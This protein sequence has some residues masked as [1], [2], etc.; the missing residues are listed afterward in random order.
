M[1]AAGHW[2]IQGF[3]NCGSGPQS[4]CGKFEELYMKKTKLFMAVKV[5]LCIKHCMY[6]AIIFN[7]EYKKC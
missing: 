3:S 2:L 7:T 4:A 1:E 6:I 5:N